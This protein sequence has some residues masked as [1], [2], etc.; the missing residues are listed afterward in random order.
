MQSVCYGCF[1]G[2]VH[3]DDRWVKEVKRSE[4]RGRAKQ[5][6]PMATGTKTFM[7]A[8]LMAI[9]AIFGSFGASNAD[10]LFTAPQIEQV[11]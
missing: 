3:R 1:T 7:V 11:D 4:A 6:E 10:P 2:K 8:A 9:A 5:D